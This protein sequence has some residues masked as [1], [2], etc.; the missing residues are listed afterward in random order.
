MDI[1]WEAGILLIMNIVFGLWSIYLWRNPNSFSSKSF[2]YRWVYYRFFS[3]GKDPE[4]P[5]SLTAKQIRKY[6][7]IVFVFSIVLIVLSIWIIFSA[8]DESTDY[9]LFHGERM[10]VRYMS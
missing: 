10:L 8:S 9:S 1:I 2:I 6:A 4:D 3:W 5:P 7:L